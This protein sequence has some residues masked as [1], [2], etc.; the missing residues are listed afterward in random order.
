M[1][2]ENKMIFLELLLRLV[3]GIMPSLK[4]LILQLICDCNAML[5]PFFKF[6]NALHYCQIFT[7]YVAIFVDVDFL[8]S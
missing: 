8:F 3:K 6:L 5:S 2:F 4:I 7:I 1:Q